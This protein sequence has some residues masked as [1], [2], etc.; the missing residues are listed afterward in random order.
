[1]S[2]L[3]LV[4]MVNGAGKYRRLT[5]DHRYVND[6]NIERGINSYHYQTTH[7]VPFIYFTELN[8]L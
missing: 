8:R 1:M 3:E 4:E 5:L 2:N 6:R 7:D